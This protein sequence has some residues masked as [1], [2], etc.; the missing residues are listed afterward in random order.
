MLLPGEFI[1]VAEESGLIVDM[2]YWIIERAITDVMQLS[3]W[4]IE[5]QRIG[6]NVSP[7]QLHGDEF[8]AEL[9][10]LLV[11]Y[12]IAPQTLEV[13]ITESLLLDDVDH[14]RELLA[15][16]RGTGV[17]LALD[18][19]GTGYSSLTYVHQLPFDTVKIDRSFIKHVDRAAESAAIVEATL[20]MARG[21]GMEVVAEGV[22]RLEELDFLSR[23]GCD[24]IQGYWLSRPVP[25]SELAQFVRT[26]NTDAAVQSHG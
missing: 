16:I 12:D 10:R 20:H 25:L 9:K 11:S 7:R 4:G 5:L 18:D 6:V 3:T 17:R 23:R 24:L 1:D 19:F 2:G 13:E 15:R 8:L 22:E 21:L 26:W 14:A